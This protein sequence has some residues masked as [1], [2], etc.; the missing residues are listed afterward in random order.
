[1]GALRI[2][3]EARWIGEVLERALALCSEVY[4]LDD[5]STDETPAI[6]QSFGERVR[7]MPSPFSG[8]DEARDKNF[9]LTRIV[10]ARPDWVLWI[11]GDEVLERTGP[12]ATA[13]GG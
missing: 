13:R 6:C 5:H 7:L 12:G 11:D 4:V 10:A 1:M 9:L 8:L 3:N 2:K